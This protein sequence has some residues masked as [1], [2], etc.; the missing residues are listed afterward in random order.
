MKVDNF[1][2]N[3]IELYSI[4]TNKGQQLFKENSLIIN[5]S[6]DIKIYNKLID[7]FKFHNFYAI[8]L[9]DNLNFYHNNSLINLYTNNYIELHIAKGVITN[10]FENKINIIHSFYK[11][12]PDSKSFF[13]VE[14]SFGFPEESKSLIRKLKIKTII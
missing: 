6:I 7:H 10:Y 12:Q 14:R 13:L 2:I 1:T 9:K 8:D 4:H 11:D 3:D 5:K